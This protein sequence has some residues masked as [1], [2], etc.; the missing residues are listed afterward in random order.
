[1]RKILFSLMAL[2]FS[3]YTNAQSIIYVNETATGNEDGASWADAFTNIQDAVNAAVS[4]DQIWVAS[5]VYKPGTGQQILVS[6]A[7]EF[8]GGFPN[9]GDP[10]MNDRDASLNVTV[11]DGDFNGDDASLAFSDN[12]PR[13]MS[14]TA[15]F[16]LDGFTLKS[17]G[18]GS[19]VSGA[20]VY[21]SS[22]KGS[23]N[24]CRFESNNVFDPN[25]LVGQG[26][27]IWA[28]SSSVVE[29]ED[30]LY[31]SNCVF[32][33]N[34]AA[35]GGAICAERSVRIEHCRF[36]RN[37][38][39]VGSAISIIAP[40]A[41]DKDEV[42]LDVLS[43]VFY[44]N[45]PSNTISAIHLTTTRY[46]ANGSFASANIDFCTFYQ[47]ATTVGYISN[48]PSTNFSELGFQF[49]NNL[50]ELS[51]NQNNVFPHDYSQVT[52]GMN[53]PFY[54]NN[55]TNSQ[56]PSGGIVVGH[57]VA[58][59]VYATIDTVALDFILDCTSPGIDQ[60]DSSTIHNTD[61][62]GNPRINGSYPDIGAFESDC[63]PISVETLQR[64]GVE[65]TIYPN[66]TNGHLT[67]ANVPS[68]IAEVDILDVSGKIL[69]TIKPD[70]N[71][72]DVS[73]LVSGVYF[74]IIKT[75]NGTQ[76][77][78]FVIQ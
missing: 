42:A 58:Q 4:G 29:F 11:I 28:D 37:N 66:P 57:I 9:T 50:V 15:D 55:L 39:Q 48:N 7:M 21:I 74:V 18:D 54:Q 61:I 59:P 76:A 71:T 3:I 73:T 56:D 60:G 10:T 69:K 33:K 27:A 16:T 40:N 46:S 47:E 44:Q 72:I 63:E 64:E 36:G 43:S 8:Y 17:G 30:T 41:D 1:M 68:S 24:N 20:G 25:M 38:G 52:D 2:G 26:G 32:L 53:F 67:I 13:L 49:T 65:L 34:G 12:S 75:Q 5:G 77:K 45:S 19:A 78:R 51:D 22:A 62:N 35:N 6:N 23:I 31:I 70:T 14:F